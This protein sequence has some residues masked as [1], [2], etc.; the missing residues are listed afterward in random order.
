MAGSRVIDIKAFIDEQK[1][2]AYQW[3]LVALCFLV[4][5]ADGMDVAIMGFVAPPILHEWAISRPAFG[6]VMSAAPLGLV[7]GAL[8]AGPSSDRF[9]RKVVLLSSIFVFGIFTIATAFTSTPTEMAVLRLLTGIGLGAAMPN[10]TTLL[11][12]YAP[13]RKR[14]LM[15]TIMFTGF[16]LGSALIGFVAGWLIPTH[17]WRAVL[18]VGGA[19]PL[20]MIPLHLWLLPESARLLAVRGAAS[21]RIAQILNRVCGGRFTGEERFISNEP[22]VPSRKPI[23]ILFS[24]GYGAMTLLLWVT[25]FMGLL[26][27]YLLTGWLPTLIKDA[28]LSV[29]VAANVTAMF[30][31][32]GTIGA[33]IVGWLMDKTR[34]APVISAAYVGGGLCV[35]AVASVGAL[36]SSL[37]MLV[38]AAGF[39]MSGA[40]TGLNAFAPGR[41]PTQARATGVSWMLGM[42]RF[43]SIFGS[44][45]GGALLGLGWGFESIL[46]TLAV[47]AVLA[48]IAILFA[49]RTSVAAANATVGASH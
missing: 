3:L 9:G 29:T 40:Q 31:I 17:G 10:T 26:V 24:Q 21:A 7:I 32:G 6:L 34:P 39:C 12:E 43:G 19:L 49:Q 13:Q 8:V 33:V 47:P 27:I 4:V 16:N 46:A 44:A 35:L 38:F 36:S 15:I 18:I 42:G 45:I 25:Y 37:T 41:Y 5:T 11:S 28:G 14:A 20:V 30:Q 22:P 48:A 23:G 1:I 2:T